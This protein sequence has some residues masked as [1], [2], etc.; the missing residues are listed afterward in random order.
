MLLKI[1]QNSQENT[2]ARVIFNKVAGLSL[3]LQLYW[4]RDS[5]TG[6]FQWILRNF[7]LWHRSFPVNFAKFLK[8]PFFIEH[9]ILFVFSLGL[10]H[11]S[12]ISVT[13][14]SCNVFPFSPS[15]HSTLIL[16]F[17]SLLT[18]SHTYIVWIATYFFLVY[19]PFIFSM[20]LF[21]S[22]CVTV[23]Q[24]PV[25][26]LACFQVDTP[27]CSFLLSYWWPTVVI[28]LFGLLNIFDSLSSLS[29]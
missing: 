13:Q 16:S 10:S 18:H 15:R 22:S 1:L 28:I 8:A 6:L 26:F 17:E 14:G 7:W 29:E 24:G 23:T 11:L 27:F 4:K 3:S 19:F 20:E 21:H 5:G 2:C 9:N 12:C 25:I